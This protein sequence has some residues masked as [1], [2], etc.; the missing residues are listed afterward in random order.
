MHST[1]A[2]QRVVKDCVHIFGSITNMPI[3][4]DVITAARRAYVEYCVYLDKQK[5]RYNTIEEFN[6]DSKAEYTA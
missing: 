2:A 1:V 4:M 3:T 5:R 6:V